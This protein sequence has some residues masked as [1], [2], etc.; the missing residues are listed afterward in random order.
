[1]LRIL[2]KLVDGKNYT[3]DELENFNG[4]EKCRLIQS[5]PVTCA[6]HFDYQFNTF[7]KT[8][9]I[10]NI[11]PLGKV[12]D[13]FYRVEYQQ[14]G[15]LHIHMMLWLENA[16][17]SGVDKYDK[18][19]I[20]FID[21]ITTC[22]KPNDNHELLDLVNRQSHRYS[23]TCRKKSKNVCRFNY[24]QPPMR[25]TQILY[26]LDDSFSPTCVRRLKETWKDMKKKLNDL[27]EREDITFEQML[28]SS[29]LPEET[30]ILSIRSSL[31]CPTIFLKRK[32]KIMSLESIT[33][34]LRA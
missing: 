30:Y 34:I 27:K 24:P 19:V 32:P 16:P 8:F 4:E 22:E 12:K 26:P 10:S 20:S 9:L 14:R 5:D 28:S 15:L 13:W 21:Q 23:H 6:R 29:G 3:D 33:T 7:L 1:M 25:T 11:A 17:V 18:Y 31:N 2:G